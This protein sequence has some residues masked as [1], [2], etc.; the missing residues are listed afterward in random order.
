M[1]PT[2]Y[3]MLGLPGSGKTT[4]SHELQQEL[5]I[6]RLSLDEEYAKLGGDLTSTKWNTNIEA[7]A[8]ETIKYQ[9]KENVERGESVILDF[10]P[11]KREDRRKYREYIE[12]IGAVSYL[13]YL[14]VPH[15]ELKRRL[16]V[17]NSDSSRDTHFVTSDML[18][19]FVARFDPPHSEDYE[20]VKAN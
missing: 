2:V 13:Y 11:W 18:D 19:A 7:E 1:K 8:N 4:F 3:L 12:S 10:C 16:E 9:L 6:P 14:E 17:R 15:D 5:N 20:L